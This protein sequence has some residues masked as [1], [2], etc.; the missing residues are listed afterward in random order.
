MSV[1]A[2]GD[3]SRLRLETMTSPDVKALIEAG[4]TSVIIPCGAVEQHG[5]HLP[6]SVDADHADELAP[7]IAALLGNTVVAP[8]I[9]VGCSA[10]HMGFPGTISLE[11]ATFE[12]LCRDYCVSLARHGFTRI[13]LVSAHIGNFPILADMLP[14]LRQHISPHSS[15]EAFVDAMA[16]IATWRS[17]VEA[18]GGDGT[19][20]GGH[21]DIAETSLML[22]LRPN[23]VRMP[24]IERGRLGVLGA[25]ELEDMWRHGLQAVSANG[26]LGD[27]TGAT[28]RI[29]QQCLDAVARLMADA[30][31]R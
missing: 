13:L 30:L 9:R 19:Y 29:G 31:S 22:L 28:P 23:T 11:K 12:A 4:V 18:T 6:L 5:P 8:T 25:D 2:S 20:V 16:M 26:I 14:R 10:H 1:Q 15:V 17:A 3:L 24:L 7:R 21:A 27:P